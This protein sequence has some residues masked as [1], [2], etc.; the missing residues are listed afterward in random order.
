MKTLIKGRIEEA[1]EWG[2]RKSKGGGSVAI[3]WLWGNEPLLEMLLG[4]F[5]Y[6]ERGNKDLF[7]LPFER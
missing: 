1:E 2:K 4:L 6:Q 5:Q 3:G 7:P